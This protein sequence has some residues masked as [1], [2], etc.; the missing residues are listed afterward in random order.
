MFRFELGLYLRRWRLNR[1]ENS[2]MPFHTCA[3]VL[4]SN[5]LGRLDYSSLSISAHMLT[6][7][8]IEVRRCK[9]FSRD[10][11]VWRPFIFQLYRGKLQVFRRKI[12]RVRGF[13]EKIGRGMKKFYFRGCEVVDDKITWWARDI[14][15]PCRA[16]PMAMEN[17]G[18]TNVSLIVKL[19]QYMYVNPMPRFAIVL[20]SAVLAMNPLPR[21]L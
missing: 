11:N 7:I 10:I 8:H 3:G 21:P 12:W 5:V 2:R 14:V 17:L 19:I 13:D 16:T 1:V 9:P 4:E 15:V 6:S 18:E 20:T